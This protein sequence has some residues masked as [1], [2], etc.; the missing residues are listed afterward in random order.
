MADPNDPTGRCGAYD[1]TKIYK[2]SWSK[3]IVCGSNI[4]IWWTTDDHGNLVKVFGAY[5]SHCL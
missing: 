5:D 1:P 4:I 3:G 2:Y